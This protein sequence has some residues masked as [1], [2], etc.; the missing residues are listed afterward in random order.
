MHRHIYEVNMS[1][2]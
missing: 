2:G 1:W